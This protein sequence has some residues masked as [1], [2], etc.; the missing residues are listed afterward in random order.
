MGMVLFDRDALLSYDG[1]SVKLV[2][3]MKDICFSMWIFP[4]LIMG[5]ELN[6]LIF[7]N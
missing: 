2:E 4:L 7:L 6:S 5:K 3:A 1:S